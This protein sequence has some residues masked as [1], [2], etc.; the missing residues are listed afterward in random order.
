[1]TSMSF[2]LQRISDVKRAAGISSKQITRHTPSQTRAHLDPKY[3]AFVSRQR[4][5]ARCRKWFA[6]QIHLPDCGGDTT[7]WSTVGTQSTVSKQTKNGY[8]SGF[9]SCNWRVGM[10]PYHYKRNG[11]GKSTTRD[12]MKAY[13]KHKLLPAMNKGDILYLDNAKVQWDPKFH[14]IEAIFAK[15]RIEVRYLP[16]NSTSTLSPLDQAP[17]AV[18]RNAW[19]ELG[20]RKNKTP[21]S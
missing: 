1:M 5:G 10:G 19:N 16:S 15:K 13:F 2:E 21:Q 17:F 18:L 9:M 8:G 12:D 20:Q 3:V 7:S 14:T 4:K 11:K 6:D